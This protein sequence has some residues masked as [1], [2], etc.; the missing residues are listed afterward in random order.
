MLFTFLLLL[1]GL[2]LNIIRFDTA[3]AA[4][5]AMCDCESFCKALQTCSA[6]ESCTQVKKVT[7]VQGA[8]RRTP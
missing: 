1:G 2:Y 3:P 7:L 6:Y 8:P 4:C 5:P